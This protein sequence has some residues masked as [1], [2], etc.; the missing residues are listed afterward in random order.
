MNVLKR[1]LIISNVDNV[2]YRVKLIVCILLNLFI[3]LLAFLTPWTHWSPIRPCNSQRNIQYST[4]VEKDHEP[5]ARISLASLPLQK[6]LQ[7][8][9]NR[10]KARTTQA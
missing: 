2:A 3:W 4:L 6:T 9:D 8:I 5:K 10:E 7:N 1:N